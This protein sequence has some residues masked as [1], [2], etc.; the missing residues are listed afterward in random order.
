LA[1]DVG[2]AGTTEVA[3][4]R[5]PLGVVGLTLITFGIYWFV[6]YFKVNKEMAAMGQAHGT[7]DLGTNPGNSLLA[8]T[9]GLFVLVP[10]FV[11]IYNTWKRLNAA[12]SL[13][14]R[15]PGMEAGLGFLLQLF[16][17]PV[18]VYIFQSNL[19]KVLEAQ[20]GAAP[21]QPAP[22]AAPAPTA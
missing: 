18:G 5:N 17:S 9:L 7:E 13:A 6:W 11:S 2:I 3:R 8:T 4:I 16:L 21:A 22:P 1:Q 10:P 20:A 19:N 14:G 12:E 15:E